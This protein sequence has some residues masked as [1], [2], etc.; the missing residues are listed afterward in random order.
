MHVRADAPGDTS[1]APTVPPNAPPQRFRNQSVPQAATV[2]ADS[3]RPRT[4]EP[5]TLQSARIVEDRRR[6]YR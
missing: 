4:L 3:T 5:S 6:G 1:P 2:F